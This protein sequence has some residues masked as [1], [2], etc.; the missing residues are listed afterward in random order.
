MEDVKKREQEMKSGTMNPRD[1]KLNLAFEIVKIYHGEAEAQKAKDYFV[2]T[3]SKKEMPTEISEVPVGGNTKILDYIVAV[4]FAGSKSDARR[5]LEQG[6]VS[7][8]GEKISEDIIIDAKY[9]GKVLKV[10]K[11]DFVKIVF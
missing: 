11:K 4:G 6:G 5:K 3:F 2:N 10:G 1:A 9:A 8:D 7:I